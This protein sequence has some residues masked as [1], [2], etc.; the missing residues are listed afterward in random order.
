MKCAKLY[1]YDVTWL[2]IFYPLSRARR[3]SEF[4]IFIAIFAAALGAL[5]NI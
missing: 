4:I 1:I 5:R 3:R 2:D